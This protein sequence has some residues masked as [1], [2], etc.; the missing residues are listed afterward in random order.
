MRLLRSDVNALLILPVA[1]VIGLGSFVLWSDD[2]T[3]P[4]H[5]F[6]SNKKGYEMQE[7]ILPANVP[8]PL[9]YQSL[10]PFSLEV[11]GRLQFPESAPDYR[12]A[13]NTNV[14]PLLANEAPIAQARYPLVFI[15]QTSESPATL[16][17]VVGA[18]D[19]VN[20]YLD[21][22]GQ[23]VAD[24]YIPAWVRRYPFFS[25]QA[26]EQAEP[27]LAIDP[28]VK[29]LKKKGGESFVGQEG[30]PTD[31]L[32]RVMAFNQEYQQMAAKTR[33]L[34]QALLSAEVLEEGVMRIP[35]ASDT[36]SDKDQK[37]REIRGFLMVNEQKLRELSDEQLAELHRSGALTVAYA[38]LMSMQNLGKIFQKR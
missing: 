17:A 5:F 22:D 29:W 31:R 35:I 2:L 12:F 7:N 4:L 21:D 1:L 34:V 37:S 3:D 32:Q 33:E 16:A 15:P 38:Q 19:G 6:S 25:I 13:S 18:G 28:T 36:E 27:M 20:T 11:H 9:F 26:G 10:V 23:W 8:L 24:T 14:I 30:K